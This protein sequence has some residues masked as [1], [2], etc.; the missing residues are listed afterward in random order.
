ME[1]ESNYQKHKENPKYLKRYT[2][3]ESHVSKE[4]LKRKLEKILNL[5]KVKTQNI[6][7]CGKQLK[8]FLQDNF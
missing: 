8:Q 1:V 4:K 5:T 2:S 6:K 3:K 7:F